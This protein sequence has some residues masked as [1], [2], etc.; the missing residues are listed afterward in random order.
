MQQQQHH[1]I[2]CRI[3]R[4]GFSSE[5][6]FEISLPR[7]DVLAGTANVQYLLDA[8]R[9]PL[10]E[11]IPEHGKVIDGFVRCRVVKK[12]ADGGV[13]IEVPS[14]DLIRVPAGELELIPQ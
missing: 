9:Q 4:G 12:E 6:T 14:A 2:P 8:K 13:I 7:G 1:H 10:E 11:N 5:R 3:E